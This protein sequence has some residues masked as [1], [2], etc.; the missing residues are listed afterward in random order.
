M[1]GVGGWWQG[2]GWWLVGRP[3]L[4]RTSQWFRL[5]MLW[6]LTA[7]CGCNSTL[8]TDI[9][10]LFY[11][12]A[13]ATMLWVLAPCCGCN[14]A[15]ATDIKCLFYLYAAVTMLWVL[16]AC[17]GCNS[18]LATDIKFLFNL[19]ATATMLWVL[20]A[21]CG[22]NSTL[23]TDIKCLFNL[24]ATATQVY[25]TVTA[26][27]PGVLILLYLSE[28]L[29]TSMTEKGS[30]PSPPTP[31]LLSFSAVQRCVRMVIGSLFA[32][33]FLESFAPAVWKLS[34]IVFFL[35]PVIHL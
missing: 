26:V 35:C 22:C 27:A 29:M 19:F 23:A 14:C 31:P 24:F 12:F 1:R 3:D 16:T 25:V 5:A 28:T 8:A 10:F 34:S 18:T 17:C 4:L 13:S 11:L 33:G 15:L 21:C 2:Q 32:E 20:T 6:V 7:C 9:K 30:S